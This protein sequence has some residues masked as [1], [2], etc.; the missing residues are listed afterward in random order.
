[1]IAGG[2]ADPTGIAQGV[3]AVPRGGRRRHSADPE[4]TA[5]FVPPGT[6]LKGVYRHKGFQFDPDVG[7]MAPRGRQ[8]KSDRLDPFVTISESPP[9]G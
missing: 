2:T 9:T 6:L 8:R 4:E 5:G 3:R 1:M 7:A